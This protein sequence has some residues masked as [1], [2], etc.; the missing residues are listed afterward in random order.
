MGT[1]KKSSPGKIEVSGLRYTCFVGLGKVSWVGR[2]LG[3]R[4]RCY[5]EGLGRVSEGSVQLPVMD[6]DWNPIRLL[7]T[8]QFKATLPDLTLN[9]GCCRE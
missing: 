5:M 6:S 8:W 4:K 2:L 1:H 7:E 3:L 9:G